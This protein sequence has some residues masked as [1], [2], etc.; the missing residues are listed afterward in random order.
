MTF[1]HSYSSIWCHPKL[2]QIQESNTTPSSTGINNAATT[3]NYCCYYSLLSLPEKSMATYKLLPLQLLS[4]MCCSSLLGFYPKEMPN[5]FGTGWPTAK[6]SS[7]ATEAGG[8]LTP[9][10]LAQCRQSCATPQSTNCLCVDALIPLEHSVL[11]GTQLNSTV[12]L[13][14]SCPYSSRQYY[15]PPSHC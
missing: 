12:G 14:H 5:C 2:V 1:E 11:T 4:D 6:A 3:Q 15:I 7:S 8:R 10:T 9:E 13:S